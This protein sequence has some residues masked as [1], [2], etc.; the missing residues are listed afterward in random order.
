MNNH[1]SILHISDLHKGEN[2]DFNNLFASLCN[3]SDSYEQNIPKPEII[4]VCGDLAEGAN[5]DNADIIIRQQYN[6][7]EE[8]LNKLVDHFLNG[9]KSRII[10]VPGNHD[11]YRGATIRSMDLIP[12]EVREVAKERYFKGDHRY[13][14]NWEDF[15]F[16][17]ITNEAEYASKYQFFIEFYNRFYN[18]IRSI[19]DC[20]ML[21]DVVDLPEYNITFAIFNSCYRIDHLNQIGAINTRAIA[22]S[23]ANLSKAFKS[24]RFIVGVWHHN[25]SGIPTQT[26]YL[27]PRVLHSFMDFHIQLGLYGH[28]HHTEALYEYHDIF[29]QGKMT[30]ISSGCL[31][32]RGKAMPEGIHC[33]YNILE[34][35]QNDKKVNVTLHVRE[36]ETGW[37]IPSWRKKQINGKDSYLMEFNLPDIDYKRILSDCISQAKTEDTYLNAVRTLIAIRDKEPSADKFIDDFLKKLSNIEICSIEFVPRTIAQKISV[38][39]ACVETHAWNMFDKIVND[40]KLEGINDANI[41]ILITEANKI[42]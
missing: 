35:E 10:I 5:G 28:Q 36:D 31:Y 4:V 20:D 27:D 11:L 32:G 42:R 22:T 25:I 13:R 40:I 16:Y 18:G 37:H 6:E 15:H 21:N 8:F 17:L 33:Q 9:D 41:N 1:Y 19:D 26:N 39:G 3:D 30:L 12:D 23:Q 14:W 7:V 2:N 24:G 34:I 38:L 29:K